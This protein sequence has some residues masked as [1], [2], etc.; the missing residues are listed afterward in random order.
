MHAKYFTIFILCIAHPPDKQL[1]KGSYN[2]VYIYSWHLNDK[3]LGMHLKYHNKTFIKKNTPCYYLYII[4]A[5]YFF[6][7]L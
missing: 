2:S 7:K 5:L 3:P 1:S 6:Y 4:F